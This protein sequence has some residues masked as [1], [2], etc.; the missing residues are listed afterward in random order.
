MS[1]LD[2]VR[3]IIIE[4]YEEEERPLVS[5]LAGTLNNFMEQVVSTVNGNLDFDNINR[6]ISTFEVT[7]DSTGKPI[8]STKFSGKRGVK[9]TSVIN[10][11]NLTNTNVFP[12]NHPFISYT[13]T[14]EGIY[15]VRKI[16]GLP[17]SNKFRITLELIY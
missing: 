13:S 1:L 12:D 4:D 11:E 17:I 5:K 9:G 8:T 10:I 3:R 15:T 2:N 7:V 16:T 14:G 6:K